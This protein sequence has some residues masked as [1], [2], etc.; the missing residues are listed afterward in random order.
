MR[1][2]YAL[3]LPA[4]LKSYEWA[5]RPPSLLETC[6]T[7]C[8]L[9]CYAG[10]HLHHHQM[11]HRQGQ[12]TLSVLPETVEGAEIA[13]ASQLSGTSPGRPPTQTTQ[14]NRRPAR[15]SSAH[16]GPLLL[17]S[18]HRAYLREQAAQLDDRMQRRSIVSFAASCCTSP[19]SS[20]HFHFHTNVDLWSDQTLAALTQPHDITYC[21]SCASCLFEQSSTL[22]LSNQVLD[23]QDGA[24]GT[25]ASDSDRDVEISS[26]RS[27]PETSYSMESGPSRP[28]MSH[29]PFAP[30]APAASTSGTNQSQ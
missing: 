19:S 4:C 23:V 15:H 17:H 6:A 2:P 27:A 11:H 22:T 24:D 9:A 12:A 3:I 20:F 1:S 30:A 21:G 28:S 16:T 14:S 18:H 8:D 7:F 5:R 26:S 13:T 10:R 25:F 29:S